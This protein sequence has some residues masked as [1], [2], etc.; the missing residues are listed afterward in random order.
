MHNF[1]DVGA[2]CDWNFEVGVPLGRTMLN[3]GAAVLYFLGQVMEI[4]SELHDCRGGQPW[5]WRV[6]VNGSFV[7]DDGNCEVCGFKNAPIF[8]FRCRYFEVVG[9]LGRPALELRGSMDAELDI[10]G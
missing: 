1:R 2:I 9:L 5:S 10:L 3:P 8:G 7:R 6:A 4:H